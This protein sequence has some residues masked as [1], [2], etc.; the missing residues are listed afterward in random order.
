M[1]TCDKCDR[2]HAAKGLCKYH[3]DK[4]WRKDNIE[5]RRELAKIYYWKYHDEHREQFNTWSKQHNKRIK[6]G[7]FDVLGGKKCVRCGFTDERALQFDHINGGGTKETKDRF[8][9]SK[10]KFSRYYSKHPEEAK[11][12]LQVLCANCNWIKKHING[13]TG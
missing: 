5:R 7:L 11:K 12:K 4:T 8:N 9:K 3:Y 13:E 10:R 6:D 2:K 1:R